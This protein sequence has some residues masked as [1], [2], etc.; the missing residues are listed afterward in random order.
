MCWMMGK[1]GSEAAKMNR[2]SGTDRLVTVSRN[3]G[4]ALSRELIRQL[5]PGGKITFKLSCS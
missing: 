1:P 4:R 2:H 5:F 3:I